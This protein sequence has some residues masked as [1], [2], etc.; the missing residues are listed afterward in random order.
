MERLR[1]IPRSP[2]F[3]LPRCIWNIVLDAGNEL[4]SDIRDTTN[5]S[6]DIPP[7]FCGFVL[8]AFLGYIFLDIMESALLNYGRGGHSVSTPNV[9]KRDQHRKKN[10]A[11]ENCNAVVFRMTD[12]CHR[13]QNETPTP[14]NTIES[15]DT[16]SK[17]QNWW[18]PEEPPEPPDIPDTISTD[19]PQKSRTIPIVLLAGLLFL[20]PAGFVP[21]IGYFLYTAFTK[22][23]S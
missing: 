17:S 23:D 22:R 10:C 16:N 19:T 15:D 2:D 6:G 13:H 3:I 4:K 20:G 8:L 14:P 11:V 9:Q 21:V 1:R 18:E 7:E 5:M 12:F